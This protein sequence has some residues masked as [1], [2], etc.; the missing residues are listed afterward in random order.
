[1]SAHDPHP[2]SIGGGSGKGKSPVARALSVFSSSVLCYGQSD[3]TAPVLA[4][5]AP[6]NGPEAPA[7]RWT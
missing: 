2:G 6:L 5:M 7:P 1:M 4:V 3:P